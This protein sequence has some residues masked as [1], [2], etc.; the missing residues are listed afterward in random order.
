MVIYNL[1][2]RRDLMQRSNNFL[3]GWLRGAAIRA[4][5]GAFGADGMAVIQ[6]TNAYL[7]QL[8][9]SD[10]DKATALAGFIN[11]YCPTYPFAV[12]EFAQIGHCVIT[13]D[14]ACYF[15]TGLNTVEATRIEVEAYFDNQNRAF[16]GGRVASNNNAFAIGWD[17]TNHIMYDL[18]TTRKT[19]IDATMNQWHD[20][21]LDKSTKTGYLDGVEVASFT[22]E[23]VSTAKDIYLLCMNNNGSPAYWSGTSCT[24]AAAKILVGTTEHWFIPIENNKIIDVATGTIITKSGSGTATYARVIS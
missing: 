1:L 14:N 3:S 13:G 20:L 8:A 17:T 11:T 7:N 2:H 19:N 4:I 22:T 10:R 9:A 15:N 24:I 12:L 6:A 18:G 16:I 23:S 5:L 21:A